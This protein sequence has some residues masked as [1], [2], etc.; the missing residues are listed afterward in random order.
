MPRTHV[1]KSLRG[2]NQSSGEKFTDSELGSLK[3][4]R[5]SN[6]YKSQR[7]LAAIVYRYSASYPLNAGRTVASIYAAIRRMDAQ[8]KANSGQTVGSNS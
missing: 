7:G 6:P 2:K 1:K 8:A 4:A 5:L 3:E